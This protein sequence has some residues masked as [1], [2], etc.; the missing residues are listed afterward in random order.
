MLFSAE[1]ETIQTEGCS[2]GGPLSETLANIHMIC[3]ES[4]V[5]KPLKPVFCKWYANDINSRRK[6]NCTNQL[7]QELN[8]YNPNINLTI[9]TNPRTFLGPQRF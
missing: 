6:K 1:T 8:N 5:V 3:R 7:Y 9:E 2:M 4:D